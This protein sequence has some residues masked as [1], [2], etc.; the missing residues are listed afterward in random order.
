MGRCGYIPPSPRDPSRQ[1]SQVS[2]VLLTDVFN[3]LLL[4][5]EN[6]GLTHA[7]LYDLVKS[8]DRSNI[9]V[10]IFAE[11]RTTD[12]SQGSG[13]RAGDNIRRQVFASWEYL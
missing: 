3:G 6:P 12:D 4:K 10:E 1:I 2:L 8:K 11:G 9:C 13:F 7:A 5:R